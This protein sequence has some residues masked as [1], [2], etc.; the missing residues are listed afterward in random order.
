VIVLDA[1]AAIDLLLE[2]EPRLDWV[3]THVSGGSIHAPSLIDLEV[4]SAMR[5]LVRAGVIESRRAEIA[6]ADLVALPLARYP[7]TRLLARIWELRANVTP[8]DAAYVALAEALE[9]PLVTTDDRL[10][11]TAGHR[12]QI[13]SFPG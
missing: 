10:A 2:L 4:A 7:S 8:Y 11:R 1:S 13:E 3:E 6:L 12:A 5:K 9:A